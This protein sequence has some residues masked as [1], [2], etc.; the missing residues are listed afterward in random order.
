[1]RPRF[2]IRRSGLRISPAGSDA[3][4]TAKARFFPRPPG[5][6]LSAFR[7]QPL[8]AICGTGAWREIENFAGTKKDKTV[9]P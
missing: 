2:F 6:Q 3:R 8:A 9:E 4:E 7:N 1:V 5:L